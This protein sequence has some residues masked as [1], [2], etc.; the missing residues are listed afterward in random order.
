[1]R[2]PFEGSLLKI[3]GKLTTCYE[4]HLTNFSTNGLLIESL[5]V[6]DKN[7]ST[8]YFIKTGEALSGIF[9]RIG[10]DENRSALFVEPGSS[11]VI[12]LDYNISG[13]KNFADVE[14]QLTILNTANTDVA[15]NRWQLI[16]FIKITIDIRFACQFGP[17]GYSI[18]PGLGKGSPESDL[19]IEWQGKNSRTIRYR[20]YQIRFQR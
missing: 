11:V 4:L 9:R 7:D 5:K 16:T 10:F 13:K 14:H 6:Y 20:F 8:V 15:Y 19:Y 17:L 1:M 3:D 2:I 18:P 12:Y